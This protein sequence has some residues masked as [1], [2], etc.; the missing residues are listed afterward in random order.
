MS[1][2]LTVKEFIEQSKYAGRVQIRINDMWIGDYDNYNKIDEYLLYYLVE[3]IR[4]SN[5]LLIIDTK[6]SIIDSLIRVLKEAQRHLFCVPYMIES[7]YIG[8]A[9]KILKKSDEKG[10]YAD[11]FLKNCCD[12]WRKEIIR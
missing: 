5:N 4:V 6:N 12:E 7:D 8:L 3:E 10:T 9:I 1:D 11:E 2:K